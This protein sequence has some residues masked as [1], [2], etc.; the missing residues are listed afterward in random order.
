MG[1]AREKFTHI[2]ADIHRKSALISELN[3]WHW[4]SAR[5]NAGAHYL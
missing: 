4:K 1:D 2:I 3:H 5:G